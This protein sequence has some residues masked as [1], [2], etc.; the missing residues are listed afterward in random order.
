MCI[1]PELLRTTVTQCPCSPLPAV[2][3]IKV[4]CFCAVEPKH[5]KKS[6]YTHVV[7]ASQQQVCGRDLIV[8]LSRQRVSDLLSGEAHPYHHIWNERNYITKI[9]ISQALQ[10]VKNAL[11]HRLTFSSIM[12]VPSALMS[13]NLQC[14]IHN[15]NLNLTPTKSLVPFKRVWSTM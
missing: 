11:S 6:L 14:L 3:C 1:N 9:V 8:F 10:K 2:L 5:L 4:D 12:K 13:V 7:L 15:Q